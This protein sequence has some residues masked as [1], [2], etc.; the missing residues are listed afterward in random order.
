MEDREIKGGIA[1][2]RKCLVT[3]ERKIQAQDALG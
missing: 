2:K 1:M 3:S